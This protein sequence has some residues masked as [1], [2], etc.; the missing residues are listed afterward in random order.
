MTQNA[1]ERT[2]E[3]TFRSPSSTH[4]EELIRARYGAEVANHG[5]EWPQTGVTRDNFRDT[6]IVSRVDGVVAGRAILDAAFY[7]L[8]ELEN[9]EVSPPFRGR[10]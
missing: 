7:P 5:F 9:L 3:V 6:V 1:S 10:V 8:A 2:V 4:G